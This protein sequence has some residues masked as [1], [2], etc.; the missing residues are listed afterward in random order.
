[1][2]SKIKKAIGQLQLISTSKKQKTTNIFTFP[3]LNQIN[4]NVW[5]DVLE[6]GNLET[7]NT[8]PEHFEKL[9]DEYFEAIDNKASKFYIN[10]N[11]KKVKLAHRIDILVKCFETLT[12]IYNHGLKLEDAVAL[13]K[14]LIE[15]VNILHPKAK[16]NGTIENKLKVLEQ[17]IT[18]NTNEFKKIEVK[19]NTNKEKHSFISQVV[20]IELALNFKI[21]I[22][23]TSV[24]KYIE[25]YKIAQKHGE[26][27]K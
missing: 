4:L 25:Y 16:I 10:E 23:T 7:L 6:T 27:K 13:E 17:L 26:R 5:F 12:Y 20:S 11:F 14:K 3:S 8:T 1:M 22:N 9:Y 21:D 2:F 18:I 15:T 19:Q 24:A